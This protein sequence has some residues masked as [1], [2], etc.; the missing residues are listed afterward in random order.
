MT[1]ERGRILWDLG[2]TV[3]DGEDSSLEDVFMPWT[4]C[5]MRVSQSW[6]P[7]T[8]CGC[9]LFYDKRTLK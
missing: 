8:L 3:L 5:I 4:V 6:T 9:I 1:E 2:W 7:S